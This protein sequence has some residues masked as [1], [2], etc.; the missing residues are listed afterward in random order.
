[1]KSTALDNENLYF[2]KKTQEDNVKK[3]KKCP[4]VFLTAIRKK[5]FC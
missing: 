5:M 4:A 1:M 2:D 3:G